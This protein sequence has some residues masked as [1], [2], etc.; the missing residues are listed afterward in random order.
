MREKASR[1]PLRQANNEGIC[2]LSSFH[3]P[4]IREANGDAAI[5][6]PTRFPR[7]P[8]DLKPRFTRSRASSA[9]RKISAFFPARPP[10]SG[11]RAI[12]IKRSAPLVHRGVNRLWLR[13]RVRRIGRYGVSIGGAEGERRSD[14]SKQKQIAHETFL[15][16]YPHGERNGPSWRKFRTLGFVMR[17]VAALAY[18]SVSPQ[19]FGIFSVGES[20]SDLPNA[21]TASPTPTNCIA[22]PVPSAHVGH[23][24][25]NR[26]P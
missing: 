1:A 12:L 3:V 8:F 17:A 4:R 18:L 15:I 22:A 14:G 7:R 19:S 13:E 26:N 21:A 20:R 25:S 5:K 16:R 11:H 9:A 23:R 6:G 2:F 24:P 10:P